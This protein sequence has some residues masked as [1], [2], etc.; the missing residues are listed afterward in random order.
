MKL[1]SLLRGGLLLRSIAR[2]LLG[3]RAELHAQNA[4]LTRL[5]DAVAPAAP[6]SLSAEDL[7]R[8][9]SVTHLD[10]DELELAMAYVEKVEREQ[11][12][13]PTEEEVLIYLADEKTV[14]LHAR[15][16]ARAQEFHERHR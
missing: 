15:L 1:R 5:A 7:R 9:T 14:E 10:P 11:A 16:R 8:E 2:E 3:I 4:L 13:T 6:A 12:Y